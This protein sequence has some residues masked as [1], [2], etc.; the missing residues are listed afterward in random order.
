MSILLASAPARPPHNQSGFTL[1]ELAVV[2][3]M[4]A[5]LAALAVPSWTQLRARNAI[6]ATV[7]DFNL[8]LQFARSEAVRLNSPVTICPSSDGVNCTAS[9]YHDG[10]IV[11]VGP[12]ANAAGQQILQDVLPRTQVTF[13]TN[14]PGTFTFL[15]NGLPLTNFNDGASLEACPTAPGYET[16]GRRIVVNRTGRIRLESPEESPDVCAP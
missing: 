13:I 1:I 14:A 11:R 12:A 8:S 2:I 3:A 4:V 15:P 9:D 6:R 10:W 5:I 16:L 7:N